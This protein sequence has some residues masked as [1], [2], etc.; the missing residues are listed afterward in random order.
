MKSLR[1][2]IS[3]PPFAYTEVKGCPEGAIEMVF[4]CGIFSVVEQLLLFAR[5]SIFIPTVQNKVVFAV[6]TCLPAER[7]W[8]G[9]GCMQIEGDIP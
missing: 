1:I 5:M 7:R 4:C 9:G 3:P 6:V 2:G 8:D